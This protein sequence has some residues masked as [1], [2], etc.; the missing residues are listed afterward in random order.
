MQANRADPPD[1]AV[2]TTVPLQDVT[3]SSAL[4]QGC[5]IQLRRWPHHHTAKAALSVRG[6]SVDGQMFP[7]TNSSISGPGVAMGLPVWGQL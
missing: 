7:R 2:D 4:L 6:C 5:T 3:I 1:R